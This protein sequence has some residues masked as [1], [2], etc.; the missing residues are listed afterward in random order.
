MDAILRYQRL[1][2]LI[3]LYRRAVIMVLNDPDVP[4]NAR[5]LYAVMFAERT[6]NT[7]LQMREI[8]DTF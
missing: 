4:D 2:R 6:A 8:F 5:V 1:C 7:I 3:I